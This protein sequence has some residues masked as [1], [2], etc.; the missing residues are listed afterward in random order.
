MLYYHTSNIWDV[1]LWN[2][3]TTWTI[4]TALSLEEECFEKMGL[5]FYQ[6]LN[7]FIV[8]PTVFF[9][10]LKLKLVFFRILDIINNE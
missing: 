9:P 5:G 10:N 2:I 4:V 1:K 8:I 6:L 3:K 7:N